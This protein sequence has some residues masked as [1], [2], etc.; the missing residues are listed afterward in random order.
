MAKKKG[1]DTDQLFRTITGMDNE[2]IEGQMSVDEYLGGTAAETP[3]DVSPSPEEIPVSIDETSLRPIV[4]SVGV[5]L[6][7]AIKGETRS[8][9][10]NLLVKPSVYEAVKQKCNALG[11]SVNECINQVLEELCSK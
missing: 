6:T 1:I 7:S 2:P 5:V 10:V 8:K 11:I 9:R 3:K 4:G